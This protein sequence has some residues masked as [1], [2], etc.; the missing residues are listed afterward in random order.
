[1]EPRDLFGPGE[2]E[3]FD[4][5]VN[6]TGDH[7]MW[8]DKPVSDYGVFHLAQSRRPVKAHRYAYARANGA[9]YLFG[10]LFRTHEV[11]HRCRVKLCVRLEHL[12]W[13]PRQEN[14]RRM[15]EA[16]WGA[17]CRNGHPKPASTR[18]D[19]LG[20]AFCFPCAQAADQRRKSR[21]RLAG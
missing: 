15:R 10:S 20:R 12:E 18:T 21:K 5:K 19:C 1:V 16:L 4:S 3:R 6:V 13:V 14:L 7:W 17:A 8:L 2:Q 9:E 11:D